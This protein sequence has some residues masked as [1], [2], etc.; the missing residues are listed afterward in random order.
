MG[1][2]QVVTGNTEGNR[3]KSD[4]EK[5]NEKKQGKPE[6]NKEHWLEERAKKKKKEM[7]GE[8]EQRK[9]KGRSNV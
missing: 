7:H 3:G 9:N 5:A 1:S 8:K 6:A 4:Q 2:C